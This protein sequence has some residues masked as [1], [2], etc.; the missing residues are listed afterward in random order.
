[1][2]WLFIALIYGGPP[3][4]ITQFFPVLLPGI[5]YLLCLVSKYRCRCSLQMYKECSIGEMRTSIKTR[6][7]FTV[8]FWLDGGGFFSVFEAPDLDISLQFPRYPSSQ[9]SQSI[10]PRH[11]PHAPG[12]PLKYTE[13]R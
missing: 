4:G 11:T 10:C 6:S 13:M 1:M 9:M 8:A 7:T 12:L 5:I 3:N 2:I